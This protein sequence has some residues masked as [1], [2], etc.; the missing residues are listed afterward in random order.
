MFSSY[1]ANTDAK[2]SEKKAIPHL[3]FLDKPT[4]TPIKKIKELTFSIGENRTTLCASHSRGV[5]PCCSC[6]NQ[7]R[8]QTNGK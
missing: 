6:W 5:N 3:N 7:R 8:A 2:Y 4:N 1:V